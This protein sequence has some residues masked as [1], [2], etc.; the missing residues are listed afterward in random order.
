MATILGF[1]DGHQIT[2]RHDPI[3]RNWILAKAAEGMPVEFPIYLLALWADGSL[4]LLRFRRA[5]PPEVFC[6]H[7]EWEEPEP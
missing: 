6:V 7:L 4:L 2:P 5:G 1:P 3:N